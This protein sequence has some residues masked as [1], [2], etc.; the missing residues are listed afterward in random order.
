MLHNQ[1]TKVHGASTIIF[2]SFVLGIGNGN[3]SSLNSS[4]ARVFNSLEEVLWLQIN[5]FQELNALHGEIQSI[6]LVN[7]DETYWEDEVLIALGVV[8]KDS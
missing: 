7:V 6:S 1:I 8:G 2:L 5:S 4:V 3:T